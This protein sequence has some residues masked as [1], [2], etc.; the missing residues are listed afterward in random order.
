M[1]KIVLRKKL[2]FEP[3]FIAQLYDGVEIILQMVEELKKI[4]LFPPF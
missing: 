2:Q 1:T 4:C 3:N